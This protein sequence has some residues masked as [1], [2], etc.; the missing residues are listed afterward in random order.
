[1]GVASPWNPYHE[2][3][4]LNPKPVFV[5]NE[6]PKFFENGFSITLTCTNDTGNWTLSERTGNTPNMTFRAK[7]PRRTKKGKLYREWK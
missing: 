3:S 5:C 6:P 4:L 2:K 1:M 7:R